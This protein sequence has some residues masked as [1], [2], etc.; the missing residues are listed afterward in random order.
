MPYTTAEARNGRP[1]DT[2]DVVGM[3]AFLAS[4]QTGHITGQVIAYLGR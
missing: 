2:A 1:G 3:V 4:P